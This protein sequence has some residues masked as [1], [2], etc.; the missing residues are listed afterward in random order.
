MARLTAPTVDPDEVLAVGAE[1]EEEPVTA[2]T[3]VRPQQAVEVSNPV[4]DV[5]ALTDEEFEGRQAMLT[6]GVER[7]A[8]LQRS[9][10]IEDTEGKGKTGDWGKIAGIPRP[11][12]YKSGAE[13]LAQFYRLVPKFEIVRD[14]KTAVE[15]GFPPEAHRPNR[16]TYTVRCVLHYGDQ[17]GP[18]VGEGTG[19]CSSWEKKYLFRTGDRLCP[20]CSLPTLRMGN[21]RDSNEKEWYC[22]KKLDPNACGQ[23]FDIDDARIAEG[24]AEVMNMEPW[25]L[26]NTLV[27]IASKRAHVDSVL[28]SLGASALFTQDEDGPNTPSGERS[29]GGTPPPVSSS[30]TTRAGNTGGAVVSDGPA[31]PAG[32]QVFTGKVTDPPDRVRE[33]ER[34]DWY[35]L[36][37]REATIPSAE[38]RFV[39]GGKNHTAIVL[40]DDAYR[41]RDAEIAK[42]DE[43]SVAGQLNMVE[44][45]EGKPKMRQ[46][47][48]VTEV[49]H[50]GKVIIGGEE[51]GGPDPEPDFVGAAEAIFEGE[52]V[53]EVRHKPEPR[54]LPKAIRPNDEMID[55]TLVIL[56]MTEGVTERT[57]KRYLELMLSDMEEFTYKAVMDGAEA[58]AQKVKATFVQGEK[59]RIVG[60]WRGGL[61]V[62]TGVTAG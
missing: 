55:A 39:A 27:K 13:K 45:K 40:G 59:V 2:L 35:N 3:V 52:W 62:L 21:K 47:W 16:I 17:G 48:W 5:G 32:T 31:P 18:V 25:D 14:E 8:A 10:L 26:E 33:K 51:T 43:V 37:P 22:W 23:R 61:I 53:T 46:L 4:W 6:K 30:A 54:L 19:A 24:A 11:I 56:S 49:R 42:D 9:I 7:I 15:L 12:I 29:T 28:R 38:L 36:L 58:D 1:P 41:L 20:G 44:W 34:P 50:N 60:T 57:K